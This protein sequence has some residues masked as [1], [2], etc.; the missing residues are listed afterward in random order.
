MPNKLSAALKGT[1]YKHCY[2]A[3]VYCEDIVAGKVP[4]SELTRAA[5]K[6]HLDDLQNQTR[7]R[8]DAEKGEKVCRFAEKMPH[9]KGKWAA[10]GLKIKLEPWQAFILSTLF[11]WVDVNGLRRFDE[12]Y[13]EIPRKNAK[14][15]LAAIIGLYMF[16]ADREHGAEVYSGATSEKQAWEVFGPAL[17][18]AKKLP[19]LCERF[20]VLCHAKSL[21][22]PWTNS[23]FQ[24]VIAKPGD[25]ANPHCWIVDEYH[26]HDDDSQ[27]QTAITGMGARD[28]AMFMA[29]TTAGS[30]TSSACY[31]YRIESVKVLEN[32][33][34]NDRLFTIIYTI[35]QGDDWSD[36]AVLAKA[37]PNLGV[38]VNEE[39]LIE[40]QA[41]A[42]NNPE[43]QNPFRTKRL[44]QWVG[45]R[46]AYFNMAAWAKCKNPKLKESQLGDWDCYVGLDASS[47]CDF[48]A[49]VRTYHKV[50]KGKDYYKFFATFY[51]PES[52][53]E[54]EKTGQYKKWAQKGLISVAE[55]QEIDFAVVED[56]LITQFKSIENFIECAYD[57]TKLQYLSQRT[58]KEGIEMVMFP[59]QVKPMS[60]PTKELQAAILGGRVEHDGNPILAWMISNVVC[61]VDRKDNVYPCKEKPENKIDGAICCI[62]GVGRAKPE[63]ESNEI[64]DASDVIDSGD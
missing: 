38:S 54:E 35:D 50:I 39:K 48:T 56:D 13:I 23:K 14:S 44:N 43:Q 32:T 51:L 30:S 22:I 8:F 33:L 12:V 7:F 58:R 4:A 27:K 60:P 57:E 46:V 3:L 59:H 17:A 64:N 52:T 40:A 63:I 41:K 24:P 36:P 5:C 21:S 6:R 34:P 2:A 9:I 15:T 19:G 45:A 28:Q 10:K 62:M 31:E 55:G 18:M 47:H 25:G 26:E 20:G 42:V 29:I 1:P 37:N 61:K 16:S 11:G 53:I 49:N